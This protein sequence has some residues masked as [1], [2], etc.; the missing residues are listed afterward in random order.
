MLKRCAVAWRSTLFRRSHCDK[1]GCRWVVAALDETLLRVTWRFT[2]FKDAAGSPWGRNFGLTGV[3]GERIPNALN[4][5]FNRCRASKTAQ[6][7]KNLTI[8]SIKFPFH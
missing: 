3:L 4:V 1:L 8:I 6:F 2:L 7:S 5:A